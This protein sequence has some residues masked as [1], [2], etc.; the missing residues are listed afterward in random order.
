[1]NKTILVAGIAFIGLTGLT[2][3]TVPAA[4]ETE[5]DRHNLS[6]AEHADCVAHLQDSEHQLRNAPSAPGA[7]QPRP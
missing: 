5:C 6:P 3:C 4:S 2:A 1:M 7:Y